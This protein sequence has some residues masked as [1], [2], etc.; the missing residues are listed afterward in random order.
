M[1]ILYAIQGTGNGH[2]SRAR[3]IV[4]ELQKYGETD[5]ALSGY[6]VDIDLPFPVKYRYHGISFIF[7]RHG[8]ISI[9][10]TLRRLKIA[11]FIKDIRSVPVREY[12]VVINDF[13]PVTAWACNMR[14]VNCF[15]LSHQSAVLH[16]G[17]PRPGSGSIMGKWLL[18]HYAPATHAV[19]F[20]FKKYGEHILPPVIRK[21]VR[22]AA[23]TNNGHY[24]VYLPA[25]DDETLIR[26]FIRFKDVK[27]H[28]FSKHNKQ[29]KRYA[30]I[31]IAPVR[32]AAYIKSLASCSGALLGAGFEGPA[33]ALYLQKKLLAVPMKMQ[34]EQ[35]CNAAALADAGVPVIKG[36]SH[37]YDALILDWL[38]NDRIIQLDIPGNTAAIAVEALMYRSAALQYDST[39]QRIYLPSG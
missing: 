18:Q 37:E 27:W 16:P 38:K 26:Y 5:I 1:K 8:S 28:I 29:P 36:L 19:G 31:H 25:Y 13:E 35:Q 17:A 4:P 9:P 2:L 6:Q 39:S 14:K 23:V 22:D 30:N 3:D 21:E 15:A 7:G 33:E 10:A 32:N 20:H 11:Q 12:D 34:Y 24:T